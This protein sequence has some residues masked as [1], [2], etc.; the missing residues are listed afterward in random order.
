[1]MDSSSG[2]SRPSSRS[3]LRTTCSGGRLAS[4]PNSIIVDDY[5]Y[6]YYFILCMSRTYMDTYKFYMDS[7]G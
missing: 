7:D 3:L 6:D 4:H 2:K 1:M 5:G